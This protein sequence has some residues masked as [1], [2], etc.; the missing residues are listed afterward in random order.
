[1]KKRISIIIIATALLGIGLPLVASA[2]QRTDYLNRINTAYVGAQINSTGADFN[3]RS[4]KTI[5]TSIENRVGTIENLVN[6]IERS[7]TED[8]KS[9]AFEYEDKA[10]QASEQVKGSVTTAENAAATAQSAM[11]DVNEAYAV[12]SKARTDA[13]VSLEELRAAAERAE[14]AAATIKQAAESAK[15][16]K[17]NA[18][19]AQRTVEGYYG[20]I[21]GLERNNFDEQQKRELVVEATNLATNAQDDAEDA[22]RSLRNA[23]ESYRGDESNT[24]GRQEI[25]ALRENATLARAAASRAEDL[26]DEVKNLVANGNIEQARSSLAMLRTAA[27]DAHAY[28]SQAFNNYR[29]AQGE[30]DRIRA[31]W[32]AR[33]GL[34]TKVDEYTLLAPVPLRQN[35]ARGEINFVEYIKEMYM[36]IVAFSVVLAIFMMVLGGFQYLSTDAIGKKKD[37]LEKLRNAVI[38]LVLVLSSWLILYTIN[39]SFVSLDSIFPEFRYTSGT[40]GSYDGEGDFGGG[41]DFE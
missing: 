17:A 2:D 36:F 21:S 31:E 28:N 23:E 39:P 22:E 30:Y 11:E 33:Y 26:A 25:A 27:D 1:M 35:L 4:I 24:Y 8:Q 6:N 18:E 37:G 14:T 19:T 7:G 38:G 34:A 12:A 13:A 32:G 15:T 5:S 20:S 3:A 29:N 10:I 16:L 40:A 9:K 41:S